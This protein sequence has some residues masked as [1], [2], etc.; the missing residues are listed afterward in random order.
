VYFDA[1][2]A[3]RYFGLLDVRLSSLSAARDFPKT[4]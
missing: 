4:T 3:G 1:A 2:L